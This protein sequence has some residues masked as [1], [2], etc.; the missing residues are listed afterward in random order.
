MT[1]LTPD[2]QEMLDSLRAAVAETLERKHRLGH[3]AVIW[4]D[5]KPVLVGEDA[6]DQSDRPSSDGQALD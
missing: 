2:T 5:D 3:Y 4:Q 1:Q 6:P